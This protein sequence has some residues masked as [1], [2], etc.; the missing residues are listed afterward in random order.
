M[1]AHKTGYLRAPTYTSYTARCYSGLLLWLAFAGSS[2]EARGNFKP[3]DMVPEVVSPEC[4]DWPTRLAGMISDRE[5]LPKQIV[6][7]DEVVRFAIGRKRI[8]I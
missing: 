7:C 8:I 3:M 5:S 2:R 6:S 1:S 4:D